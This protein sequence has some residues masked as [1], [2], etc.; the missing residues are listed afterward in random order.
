MEVKEYK[1][2]ATE[3]K[4]YVLSKFNFRLVTVLAIIALVLF[5][6]IFQ[7]HI[8]WIVFG[9]FATVVLMTVFLGIYALIYHYHLKDEINNTL[10]SIN[11]EGFCF[12]YEL[13]YWERMSNLRIIYVSHYNIYGFTGN[14]S[15]VITFYLNDKRREF[16]FGLNGEEDKLRYLEMLEF[17]YLKEIPFIEEIDKIGPTYLMEPIQTDN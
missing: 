7:D 3:E 5:L 1:F 9:L 11:E 17:L 14:L 6:Q 13:I 12:K 4:V 10:I 8:G 2:I 16:H 15:N